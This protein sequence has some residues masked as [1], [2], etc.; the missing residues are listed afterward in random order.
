MKYIFDFDDVLFKNTKMLK[1][2]MFR[3][4]AEKTGKTAEEVEKAYQ[5]VRKEFSLVNFIKNSLTP[6][7]LLNE[8]TKYQIDMDTD[9]L[10]KEIMSECHKFLDPELMAEI[11]RIDKKDL[12]IVTNGEKKFNWEKLAYS[13]I[14]EYLDIKHIHVVPGPKTQ[15]V[16]KICK[17]NPGE[18]ILFFD[19]RQEFIDGLD[20]Q[21]NPRFK[22]IRYEEEKKSEIIE[23]LREWRP[24]ESPAH[25]LRKGVK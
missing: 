10:F 5:E 11:K 4:I 7:G 19:D 15:A 20:E 3:L 14:L 13:G 1:P 23:L 9:A 25:E 16:R 24:K 6:E 17:D 8:E 2:R 18:D 12:Y 21:D 22:A